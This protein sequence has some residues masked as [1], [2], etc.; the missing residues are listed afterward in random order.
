MTGHKHYCL[1]IQRD[2]STCFAKTHMRAFCPHWFECE[3]KVAYK[4]DGRKNHD[5]KP[6]SQAPVA[7]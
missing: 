1:L 7:A 2:M 6:L 5:A 4:H 3:V